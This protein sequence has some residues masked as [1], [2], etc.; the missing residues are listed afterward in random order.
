MHRKTNV[1]FALTD[2]K[3]YHLNELLLF[4]IWNILLH[5]N[6][7][8][9][10]HLQKLADVSIQSDLQTCFG[11]CIKKTHP[12]ATS[13]GQG[14]RLPLRTFCENQLFYATG[15]TSIILQNNKE[16]EHKSKN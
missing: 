13:L 10:L 12:H 9:L 2:L 7:L 14:L 15:L 11:T 8:F 16:S 3:S 6:C 5:L 4:Y 1:N